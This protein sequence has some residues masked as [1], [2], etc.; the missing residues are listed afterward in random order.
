MKKDS[1]S[2]ESSDSSDSDW[3]KYVNFANRDCTRSDATDTIYITRVYTVLFLRSQLYPAECHYNVTNTCL[4]TYYWHDHIAVSTM[5]NKLYYI[6]CLNLYD[7][8]MVR[9]S[10]HQ[11]G[12]G[13]SQRLSH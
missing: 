3:L 8:R 7:E 11:H 1:D 2:S 13:N 5:A 10:N 4:C 9:Q 12:I 6:R